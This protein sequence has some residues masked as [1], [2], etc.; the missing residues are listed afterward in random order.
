M[1]ELWIAAAEAA[2]GY[3]GW[4]YAVYSGGEAVGTAGGARR[5]TGIAMAL[6]GLADALGDLGPA[7]RAQPLQVHSGDALLAGFKT[8]RAAGWK[9]PKGETLPSPELWEAAAAALDRQTG[10]WS[11]VP[12]HAAGTEFAQAWAVFALDI[13]RTKGTFASAIPK[14]NLKTLV[15]KLTA[16]K[17]N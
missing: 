2:G 10:G 6:T 8:L 12:G 11:F 17:L 5:T 13:A 14:P 7:Q 16:G 4:G 9:T 15:G 1:I 3:G